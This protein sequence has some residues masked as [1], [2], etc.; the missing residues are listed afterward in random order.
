MQIY[1]LA[2]QCTEE[3]SL[4]DFGVVVGQHFLRT[5]PKVL[6]VDDDSNTNFP[7]YLC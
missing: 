1:Y 6:V 7:R 4:E 5:Y 3:L 2:K